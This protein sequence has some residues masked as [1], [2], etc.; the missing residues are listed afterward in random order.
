MGLGILEDRVMDHVPG[1]PSAP[2]EPQDVQRLTNDLCPKA[3]PGTLTIPRDLSTAVME[4]R[5]SN[6]TPAVRN[7]SSWYAQGLP[8]SCHGR[9]RD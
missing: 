5:D 3:Q 6:A 9:T 7:P 4:L 8:R 1:K 2:P